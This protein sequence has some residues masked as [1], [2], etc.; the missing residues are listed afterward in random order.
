V[1]CSVFVALAQEAEF[2]LAAKGL[3]VAQP[4]PIWGCPLPRRG[5]ESDPPRRTNPEPGRNGCPRDPSVSATLSHLSVGSG[6][7]GA[8]GRTAPSRGFAEASRATGGADA[9][10][11]LRQR[12]S[13]RRRAT[14]SPGEAAARERGSDHGRSSYERKPGATHSRRTPSVRN[15]SSTDGVDR[16]ELIPSPWERHDRQRPLGQRPA[17]RRACRDIRQLM[18]GEAT[19]DRDI[20][21]DMD[22]FHNSRAASAATVARL[23][24][25]VQTR[26]VIGAEQGARISCVA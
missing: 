1:L 20:V 19:V 18:G 24:E 25:I 10:D 13:W 2:G 9:R 14:A 8:I 17:R 5:R 22:D 11:E 15:V 4:A 7:P 21:V 6:V 3:S 16:H 12:P 26:Q 23:V